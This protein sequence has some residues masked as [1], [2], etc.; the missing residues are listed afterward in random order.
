MVVD[1][2]TLWRDVDPVWAP[3]LAH[4]APW[5]LLDY[6][7]EALRRIGHLLG[8]DYRQ[9]APEVWVHRT[10]V[11][12]EDVPVEGP[13][14]LCEGVVVR[15]A[16]YLRGCVYA[17]AGALVGHC[18][19][20][21]HAILMRKACCPHFNY[22]GD[23]ILGVAA[24]LGAGAIV[25][26]VRQDGAPVWVQIEGVHYPTNRRKMGALVGDE[27]EVGASAVLNPGT[28]LAAR[29]RVRPLQS[30]KGYL[31]APPVE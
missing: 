12:A 25:C 30:V 21:K 2:E 1:L 28:V 31:S 7:P 26:N 5:Q 16:A 3:Y 24:H 22:V 20:V 11:V 17:G 10:A 29:G 18:T 19:E 15:P 13:C 14:I 27:A 9:P 4:Q 6:L 8:E 23:S